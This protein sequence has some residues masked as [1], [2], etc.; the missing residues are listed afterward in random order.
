M[1]AFAFAI[2]I[3]NP[4]CGL[5]GFHSIVADFIFAAL[6]LFRHCRCR[7]SQ[8][9]LVGPCLYLAASVPALLS[10]SLLTSNSPDASAAKLVT[11]IYLL[12]IPVVVINKF[13]MKKTCGRSFAGSSPE[14]LSPSR[15]L[16]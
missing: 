11:Q 6:L 12:S 13:V 14:P 8:A 2:P 9:D 16:L 5:L 4:A 15:W 7:P 10:A 3:M 1:Y